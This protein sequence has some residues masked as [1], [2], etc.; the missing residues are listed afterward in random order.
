MEKFKLSKDD[1]KMI[2]IKML[3]GGGKP[4]DISDSYINSF[5]KEIKNISNLLVNLKENEELVKQ[6]QDSDKTNVNGCVMCMRYQIIENEILQ[7]AVKFF[8]DHNFHVDVLVFD[9]LMIRKTKEITDELLDE[10]N[11]HVYNTTGYEVQFIIKPMNEGHDI[12]DAELNSI[13]NNEVN[14]SVSNIDIS[15]DGG[16]HI[17]VKQPDMMKIATWSKKLPEIVK[18]NNY[19]WVAKNL[20]KIFE[21]ITTHYENKNTL[22]GHI[23]VLSGILRDLDTLPG[24][25]KKYSKIATDLNLELQDESK[26]QE[27]LP[28]R[29][30]NFVLFGDIVKR[31]EQF[32]KLFEQ[33]RTNNKK[34]LSWVLLSLYTM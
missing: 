19:K 9:G 32:K 2:F 3:N 6:A 10:L 30:N 11:D 27:L 4:K 13:N 7:C 26:K 14:D 5:H 22:K 29:K 17:Q 8:V 12:P 16:E 1:A 24:M 23:S 31:R 25:Q 28:Q 15:S 18:D 21:Y 20:K 33:D 34:N